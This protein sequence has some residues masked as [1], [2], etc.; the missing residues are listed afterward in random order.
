MP[1]PLS[2][3]IEFPKQTQRTNGS[4]KSRQKVSLAL[5]SLI[6]DAGGQKGF[7]RESRKRVNPLTRNFR[8]C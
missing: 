5:F 4:R 3:E 1:P 7:S 2:C 8:T 6:L